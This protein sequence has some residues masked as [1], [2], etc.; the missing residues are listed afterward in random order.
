MSSTPAPPCPRGG[1]SLRP[2]PR[3]FNRDESL[4]CPA[5][6]YGWAD[7]DSP[8]DLLIYPNPRDR[9]SR[10]AV[11]V[12]IGSLKLLDVNKV[13]VPPS[14][15]D[16]AAATMAEQARTTSDAE[17][18]GSLRR[19]DVRVG[20]PRPGPPPSLLQQSHRGTPKHQRRH[21]ETHFRERDANCSTEFLPFVLTTGG[22]VH[23]HGKELLSRCLRAAGSDISSRVRFR[24]F[25]RSR[26]AILLLRRAP[27]LH[28]LWSAF[29]LFNNSPPSSSIDLSQLGFCL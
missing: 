29:L 13:R 25:L 28:V 7:A 5:R 19:A 27:V 12:T 6:H 2:R 9:T 21:F 4:G 24:S 26:L 14:P 10:W 3:T 18:G 22:A 15:T 1:P 11:D 20:L 17:L 23:T 16:L 8:H